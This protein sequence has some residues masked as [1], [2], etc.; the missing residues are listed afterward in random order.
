MSQQSIPVLTL[1]VN[2][3]EALV[4]RRFVG[5]DGGVASAGQPALGVARTAADV[6]DAAAVDV[7][8]TAVVECGTVI[9]A[10]GGVQ[11]DG[12]GRAITLAA[13][14]KVGRLAPGEQSAGFGDVVEIILLPS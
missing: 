11:V 4:A 6:G 8:G 2:A 9:A 7:M 3:T 14:T 12:D 5:H 1:T 10:G 13:G